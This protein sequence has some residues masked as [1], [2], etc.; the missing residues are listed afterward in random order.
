M[1][2]K[3]IWAKAQGIL[4]TNGIDDIKVYNALELLLAPKNRV[5]DY[6]DPILNEKGEIVELWCNKHLKYEPIAEFKKNSKNK[7]GY[8]KMCKTAEKIWWTKTKEYKEIENQINALGE[9]IINGEMTIKNAK[10]L[11]PKLLE[12]VAQ[13]KNERDTLPYQ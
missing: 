4:E 12:E 7:S 9:K 6:K 13:I 2:K 1:T 10:A 8:E 11:R 3:E 5:A